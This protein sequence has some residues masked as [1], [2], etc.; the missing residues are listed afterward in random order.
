MIWYAYDAEKFKVPLAFEP[1][2][3]MF[4]ETSFTVS[5]I[6]APTA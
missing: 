1:E 3:G 5:P 4:I 6:M 2:P